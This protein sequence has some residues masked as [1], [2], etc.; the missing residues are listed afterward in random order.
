[1]IKKLGH[2]FFVAGMICCITP[3]FSQQN[4]FNSMPVEYNLHQGVY[5]SGNAG[6]GLGAYKDKQGNVDGG[7][8]GV[9]GSAA[10]GYMFN[11]YV[12][13]EVG[14]SGVGTWL[15]SMAI[16]DVALKGNL[17]AGPRASLYAKIGGA[18][19]YNRICNP[20]FNTGLCFT[21]HTGGVFVGAGLGVAV[22]PHF[23]LAL[24]YNGIVQNNSAGDGLMGV[25]GLVFIYH[26]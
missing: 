9:G 13:L 25:L 8:A 21:S 18:G 3:T 12:G 2:S 20:L 5:I 26:F 15:G 6:V 19:I 23:D 4:N 16:Y 22:T 24:E 17:P 14:G 7:V 11:P 1:M 10:L